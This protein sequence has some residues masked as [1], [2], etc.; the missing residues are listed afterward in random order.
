MNYSYECVTWTYHRADPADY[1]PTQ[2]DLDTWD[3]QLFTT[4][5]A[6]VVELMQEFGITNTKESRSAIVA[7]AEVSNGQSARV[8][9][10]N[11]CRFYDPLP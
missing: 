11:A 5:D 8:R 10:R 3:Q 6:D 1:A 4:Y 7:L 9:V 2:T